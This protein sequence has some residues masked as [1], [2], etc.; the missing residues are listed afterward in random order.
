MTAEIFTEGDW[1]R[2]TAFIGY[3]R[4]D[5][6]FVFVGAEERADDAFPLSER[7]TWSPIMDMPGLHAGLEQ[8]R[9]QMTLRPMCHV[10]LR[11]AGRHASPQSR[12]AY[13]RHELGAATGDSLLME[14]FPIPQHNMGIWQGPASRRWASRDVYYDSVWPA[15]RTL[16]V[17]TLLGF[18]RKLIVCYTKAHWPRYRQLFADADWMVVDAESDIQGALW[19]GATVLLTHAFSRAFRP[20]A[21]LERLVRACGSADYGC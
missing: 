1:S 21:A 11:A 10:M 18:E 6:P 20:N 17:E 5:A 9:V 13:Q 12:L 15:R 2:L 4:E 7:R 19:N 16:I 14:L 8:A 3:G